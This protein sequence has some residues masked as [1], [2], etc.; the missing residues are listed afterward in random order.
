MRDR[1]NGLGHGLSLLIIGVVLI[2][3]GLS[4]G[5]QWKT[6]GFFSNRGYGNWN[7]KWN[8][9]ENEKW[10]KDYIQ[11]IEEISGV[12][13]SDIRKMSFIIRKNQLV[14]GIKN[15]NFNRCRT[16]IYTDFI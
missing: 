14:L 12:I 9:S 11:K 4:L 15:R 7:W 2:A 8:W 16:N 10:E 5:G 6:N 1:K 13:G 3:I